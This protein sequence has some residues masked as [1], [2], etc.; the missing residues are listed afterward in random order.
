[1]KYFIRCLFLINI[2]LLTFLGCKINNKKWL[3]FEN[4]E[5]IAEIL[6]IDKNNTQSKFNVEPEFTYGWSEDILGDFQF[7]FI[8]TEDNLEGI[9]IVSNEY[10]D[11]GTFLI[12]IKIIDNAFELE[13]D[14]N[15]LDVVG[16]FIYD[17]NYSEIKSKYFMHYNLII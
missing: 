2:L 4:G 13:Y 1:M 16:Y 5:Y 15:N 8:K 11:R 7:I 10:K 14:I 3:E 17:E 9:F 6:I 12:K